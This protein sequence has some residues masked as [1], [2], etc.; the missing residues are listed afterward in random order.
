[1]GQAAPAAQPMAGGRARLA[2]GP[3]PDGCNSRKAG[4]GEFRLRPLKQR[5]WCCCWQL[6][7]VGW[8]RDAPALA[9][10]PPPPHPPAPTTRTHSLSH[11][12]APAPRRAQ[13]HGISHRRQR[14]AAAAT[15]TGAGDAFVCCP[16]AT[17]DCLSFCRSVG[18]P[19]CLSAS[20]RQH[21]A[22]ASARRRTRGGLHRF[23]S[24]AP[25]GLI[26]ARGGEAR[27]LSARHRAGQS[28]GCTHMYSMHLG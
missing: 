4:R 25:S 11:T 7:R 26:I 1:M 28:R 3:G 14:T 22:S 9:L 12:H 16:R 19:V 8:A 13:Q 10:S 24:R 20:F 27:R 2:P 18:L 21:R 15:S 17:A 6:S 5:R 23:D